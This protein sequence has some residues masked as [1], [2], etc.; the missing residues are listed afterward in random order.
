MNAQDLS[1][2]TLAE[3][4]AIYNEQADTPIKKFTCSK[5][6]AIERIL[7][8]ETFETT[9]VAE[10]EDDE[11]EE[12]VELDPLWGRTITTPTVEAQSTKPK[13]KGIGKRIIEL[14]K[15]KTP[16]KTVLETIKLEFEGCKTTMACVYWYASKINLGQY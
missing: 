16:T 9:D 2:K 7:N 10:L 14:L 13:A 5:D 15:D 8:L 4:T 12:V 6:K 11:T 3:L 1:T